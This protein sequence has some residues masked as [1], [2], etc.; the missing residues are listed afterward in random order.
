MAPSQPTKQHSTYTN[1]RSHGAVLLTLLYPFS[2]GT[3]LDLPLYGSPLNPITISFHDYTIIFSLSNG[4]KALEPPD[5]PFFSIHFQ[6]KNTF[7]DKKI[8]FVKKHIFFAEERVSNKKEQKKK[9]RPC[10]LEKNLRK[11][12]NQEINIRKNQKG[13]KQKE[14]KIELLFLKII[15]GAGG[16]GTI[17]EILRL[18]ATVFF[19]FSCNV[20]SSCSSGV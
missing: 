13:D 15:R 9:S 17:M 6:Q 14:K 19:Y 7:F 3:D 2:L 4:I 10:G 1:A 16:G 5:R 12:K 11:K 20:F 18:L 8:F